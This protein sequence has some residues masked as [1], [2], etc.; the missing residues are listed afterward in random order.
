MKELLNN[1]ISIVGDVSIGAYAVVLIA[2]VAGYFFKVRESALW[3]KLVAY[4][5]NINVDVKPRGGT[6]GNKTIGA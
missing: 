6:S 1:L 2:I 4:I 5:G 3:R